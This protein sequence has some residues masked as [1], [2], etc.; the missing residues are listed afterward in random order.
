MAQLNL[1]DEEYIISSDEASCVDDFF[2]RKGSLYLTNTRLIFF[3]T[4]SWRKK[5]NC[6][7]DLD[8]IDLLEPQKNGFMVDTEKGK[9]FFRGTGAVRIHDRLK[10]RREALSIGAVHNPNTGAELREVIYLQG[11]INLINNNFSSSAQLFFTSK[12]LRIT[13]NASWFRRSS[14]IQTTIENI[15][16]FHFTL[17]SKTLSIQLHDNVL[18]IIFSG[19]L[20]PPLY[21]TLMGHQDGGTAEKWNCIEVG[22]TRGLLK[23]KGLLSITKK[24]VAFCPT[25]SLDSITQSKELD[26]AIED[27]YKIERKGWPEKNITLFFSD[28]EVMFTTNNTEKDFPFFRQAITDHSPTPPWKVQTRSELKEVNKEWGATLKPNAEKILLICW[29]AQKI[30]NDLFHIGW[31]MLS[32]L[33]VRFLSKDGTLK[34][35]APVLQ[36]QKSLEQ[37]SGIRI[38]YKNKEFEFLCF[39][40]SKFSKA[41]WNKVQT[42]KPPPELQEARSGQ[43]LN[44]V[45]GSSPVALIF[46]NKI[47]VHRLSLIFVRKSTRYLTIQCEKISYSEI[48][49]GDVIEVEIPK[50]IG[51]FRFFSKVQTVNLITPTS[52]GSYEMTIAHPDNIY[53]YNQRKAF[54]IPLEQECTVSIHRTHDTK[55][56]LLYE[57][58]QQE[59]SLDGEIFD[60]SFG[61]CGIMFDEDL[62]D[63]DPKT[64]L[65]RFSCILYD[66]EIKLQGLVRHVVF[67][68]NI[69]KWSHGIEF[70]HLPDK[71]EQRI[72]EHVLNLERDMLQ[73]EQ[74]EE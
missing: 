55:K 39:G 30:S 18:P 34:W 35:S 51:R 11:D 17:R 6:S 22:Y 31:L 49:K 53:I 1:E 73:K 12:E 19:S 65:L 44:K 66:E 24:R 42:L 59:R 40:G 67:K 10:L 26:I 57:E 28:K 38:H 21:L 47:L 64:I 62:N 52:S 7:I 70:I 63:A 43:D 14:T 50:I 36:I 15:A 25:E 46:F 4:N 61:G 13:T 33:Q 27:I 23:I 29:C 60:V 48:K 58:V 54:R 3:D 69:Q 45:L 32:N 37:Y 16:S 2:S 72:F 41:F 74:E 5:K 9:H 68:P 71:T 8:N 56:H 20:A